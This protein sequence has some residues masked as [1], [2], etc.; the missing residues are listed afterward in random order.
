MSRTKS[1]QNNFVFNLCNAQ[2]GSLIPSKL[3]DSGHMGGGKQPSICSHS[4]DVELKYVYIVQGWLISQVWCGTTVRRLKGKSYEMPTPN[5]NVFISFCTVYKISLVFEAFLCS[6]PMSTTRQQKAKHCSYSLHHTNLSCLHL[7]LRPVCS[8]SLYQCCYRPD[9]P[10]CLSV[11]DCLVCPLLTSLCK[12]RPLRWVDNLPGSICLCCTM[13]RTCYQTQH[14][15]NCTPAPL[16]NLTRWPTN[17]KCSI[18]IAGHRHG[19][20]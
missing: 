17:I 16:Q 5:A 10:A 4:W 20:N 11:S 9:V 14:S 6:S 12:F 18:I 2:F 3:A 8:R 15:R 1:G 19:V 7:S 13:F